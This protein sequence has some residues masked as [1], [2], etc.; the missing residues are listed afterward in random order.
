MGQSKES[1][2][3]QLLKEFQSIFNQ[4]SEEE[5]NHLAAWINQWSKQQLDVRAMQNPDANPESSLED[6][7]KSTLFSLPLRVGW[8]AI[9]AGIGSLLPVIRISG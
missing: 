2:T 7:G 9:K 5:K 4:G 3:K 6:K 8:A 1:S